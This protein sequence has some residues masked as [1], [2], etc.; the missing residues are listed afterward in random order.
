MFYDAVKGR[1]AAS[2][3]DK[4][5]TGTTTHPQSSLNLHTK[6][7]NITS[8]LAHPATTHCTNP[9]L[10]YKLERGTATSSTQ[11]NKPQHNLTSPNPTLTHYP[12]QPQHNPLARANQ[13]PHTTHKYII[14]RDPHYY[15]G[16]P[17]T[18]TPTPP[19]NR[20]H[21]PKHPDPPRLNKSHKHHSHTRNVVT[22]TPQRHT[23]APTSRH[24]HTHATPARSH[25]SQS[26]KHHTSGSRSTDHQP[27]T[28]DHTPL[29]ATTSPEHTQEQRPIGTLLPA[30]ARNTP[31]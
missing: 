28:T 4:P 24:T 14:P 25:K 12:K 26:A 2:R 10:I 21:H 15:H 8:E 23:Q 31:P 6:H 5:P 16:P 11:S 13:R 9:P 30:R 18:P 3:D 27:A 22:G 29:E 19:P 17:P 1:H 7:F 20:T